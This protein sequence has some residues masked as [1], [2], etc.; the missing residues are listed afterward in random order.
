MKEGWLVMRPFLNVESP[1]HISKM[2]EARAVKFCK[3]RYDIKSCQM[4][5]KLTPKQCSCAHV[6]HFLSLIHI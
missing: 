3:Q 6:T 2:A 4:N 5:D 1:I